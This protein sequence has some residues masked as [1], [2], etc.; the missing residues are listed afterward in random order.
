MI[1]LKK[2]LKKIWRNKVF[3][4]FLQT[5]LSTFTGGFVFGLS[6]KEIFTLFVASLSAAICTIMNIGKYDSY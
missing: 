1:K 2:I 5:F 4:T 3:R 6:D